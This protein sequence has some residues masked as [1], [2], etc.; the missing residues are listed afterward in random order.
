MHTFAAVLLLL[1]RP[2]WKTLETGGWRPTPFSTGV[3]VIN[4]AASPEEYFIELPLAANYGN[5]KQI[6]S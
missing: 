1:G 2:F 3:K 6:F 5:N 4:F